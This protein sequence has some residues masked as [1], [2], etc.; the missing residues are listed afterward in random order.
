MSDTTH[1]ISR[2]DQA[3]SAQQLLPEAAANLKTWLTGGFLPPYAQSALAELIGDDAWEELNDRFYRTIAFGTGGMRTRTIGRV[4]APSEQGQPNAEGTPAHPAVGANYLNDFNIA[5]ATIG[6]Y[7]HC[8][9]YLDTEGKTDARPSLVIAHDMR[10]FSRH[11]CELTASVWARL[12]GQAYIFDGPR[13][14]PQLSFSVRYLKATTGIVITASHNPPH[15]NGYKV[16]FSDG[17]QVVSPHAEGIIE[18]FNAVELDTLPPYLEKDLTRVITLDAAADKA[19]L[20]AAGEVVIDAALL[21]QHPP[22]VVFSPI[23]GCGGVQTPALLRHFGVEPLLVAD[24]MVMDPR[25]PT[26]KSPNPENAEAL[27]EGIALAT[28]KDAD[29]MMATDPDGDRMGV[30]VRNAKGGMDLMTGNQ[31]GSVLAE[32][33]LTRLKEKGIIPAAG[34]QRIALIKTFVTTPLQEAIAHAHGAKCVDTLTG[35]KWIGAKLK[36]YEDELLAALESSGRRVEYDKLPLAERITLLQQHSTF[37]VFGGEES[38]GYLASDAVRDKDG[39]AAVLMFTE[40]AAYL[41]Q[42]G[43]TFGDYLDQLYLRHGY[44]LEDLLNI[45][46]EGAAGSAKI[47]NILDS[48]RASPPKAINGVAVTKAIDFGRDTLNDADGKTIP[49]E[50]FYFYELANGYRFAVRGSGTEPKIKFYLFA[51]DPVDGPGVLADVKASTRAKLNTLKAE[52]EAE[53]HRRAGS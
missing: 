12:G 21:R 37:F 25:F 8:A 2:V 23:H 24:Q 26:V 39:S 9:A 33:R 49:A 5:R 50:N 41:K 11:F 16:Y 43:L 4:S 1:L 6:L 53:A 28:S 15:D 34:S 3:L 42:Q 40:L 10:H 13:S 52:L 20:A 32:Y 18:Q 31:I 17:A 30:A 27:T 51:H 46:Y 38:Y 47:K 45:Y 48:L 35:F 14:T 44:Y 36:D 19:Y 7:R 29:V 22:R